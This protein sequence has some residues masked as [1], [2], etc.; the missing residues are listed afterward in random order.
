MMRS[1]TEP[2]RGTETQPFWL[3]RLAVMA[4]LAV[5]GAACAQSDY[6]T[7]PIRWIVPFGPGG[8]ADLL[9][10]MIGQRLSDV[11]GQPIIVDNRSGAAGNIGVSLAARAPA[12][13]Y[14]VVFGYVGTFG[15]NPNMYRNLAWDPVRDFAP[16]V[17]MSSVMNVLVA[18]PGSPI[19]SVKELIAL[20][21]A[22]PGGLSYGSAGS[23]SLPHLAAELF[24][25][26]TAT[27]LLHVPFKSGGEANI[28]LLSGQVDL[29][30]ADP[31]VS[32]PHIKAGRLRAL[33]VSTLKRVP[34]LPDV[35]TMIEAG[36]PGYEVVSWNGIL[37]PAG[38]PRSIIDRL[39][40]EIVKIIQIPEVHQ[41]MASQ[42]YEPVVGTP[43]QFGALIK[44]E[45]AK[46]AKVV[47]VSGARID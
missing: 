38:T 46:W 29:V 17:Q 15:I 23:G 34:Q 12:D 2:L 6:P 18:Q 24:K 19:R 32:I 47:K 11:L 21:K 10:R 45:L 44:A 40:R 14:T 43:E 1:M 16:I 35:P 4:M 42:G 30:F 20:A 13:G 22:K 36:V 27:D 41:R 7:K 31:L 25:S 39:N 5:A 3:R 26:M 8:G 37:A 28:G 9:S 33:A